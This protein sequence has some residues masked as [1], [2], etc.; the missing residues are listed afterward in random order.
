MKQTNETMQNFKLFTAPPSKNGH[1]LANGHGNGLHRKS[2][3]VNRLSDSD[4][5]DEYSLPKPKDLH[6]GNGADSRPSKKRKLND[7]HIALQEQRRQLPIYQ[8]FPF[9]LISAFLNSQLS[10]ADKG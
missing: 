2:G 3:N 5:D 1:S 4:D 10:K 9:V 7:A 8:G 6:N